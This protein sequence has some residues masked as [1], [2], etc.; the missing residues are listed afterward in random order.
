MVSYRVHRGCVL[1]LCLV[2]SQSVHCTTLAELL[3]SARERDPAMAIAQA[4]VNVAKARSS[5]AARSLLPT[6]TITGTSSDNR[7]SQNK[8]AYQRFSTEQWALQV[9]Q[10]IFHLATGFATRAADKLVAQAQAQLAATESE[11]AGRVATAWFDVITSQENLKAIRGQKDATQQ[12]LAVAKRSFELGAVSVADV[13]EVEAKHAVVLVQEAQA[14]GELGFKQQTLSQLTATPVDTIDVAPWMQPRLSDKLGQLSDWLEQ[15]RQTSPTVVQARFEVEAS[16][17]EIGR[18][19]SAL[20]PSIDL[21]ANR[22][23]NDATGSNFSDAPTSS[24]SGQIGVQLTIPL[25]A[26]LTSRGK[27]NEAIAL[28][29][30]T[31]GERDKTYDQVMLNI[32]QAY[33]GMSSALAQIP[34]LELAQQANEVSVKASK[35]GYEVGMR[36]NV[37]VLN[38][39]A[40]LFQTQKDLAKARADAWLNYMRLRFLTG[41][42]T[43]ADLNAF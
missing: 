9:N 30:K 28:R 12:Q 15:A 35:R 6:A 25:T 23:I 31:L 24:K 38:A 42:W 3:L 20:S 26:G 8:A 10:Q 34:A 18:A 19:K 1:A 39:L 43:E 22:N 21:I 40:Q 41:Q 33:L 17:L 13:R 2:V 14:L 4:Q 7:N 32:K 27:I 5:D 16:E 11:L 36:A 29:D 37:D